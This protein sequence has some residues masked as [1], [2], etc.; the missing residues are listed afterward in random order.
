MSK[1]KIEWRQVFEEEKKFIQARRK[2]MTPE[3]LGYKES[4]PEDLVG[5]AISGGGIRS[6]TFG[7]GVLE[8]LK[9]KDL[10]NK[11]D[12]LS[13]VSGGGYI[14]GWL[15]ANCYRNDNWLEKEATN[16]GSQWKESISYLR[17]FS[18]Y[19][20][21][22]LGLLSADT[23][24]M[25]TVWLRNSLLIL[26]MIILTIASLLLVTKGLF[27][28]FDLATEKEDFIVLT[29]ITTA[30]LLIFVTSSITLYLRNLKHTLSNP[31][32]NSGGGQG[33]IHLSVISLMIGCF[34]ISILFWLKA[35]EQKLLQWGIVGVQ[36]WL[37]WGLIAWVFVSSSFFSYNSIVNGSIKI[38]KMIGAIL[39]ALIPTIVSWLLF[40]TIANVALNWKETGCVEDKFYAFAIMPAALLATFAFDCVLLIGMLGRASSDYFREWWSRFGAWLAIYGFIWIIFV[41]VIYLGPIIIVKHEELWHVITAISTAWLG[42]TLAGVFAGKSASTNGTN[43]KEV[44]AKIKDMVIKA[45]PIVFILGLLVALSVLLHLILASESKNIGELLI[46]DGGVKIVIAFVICIVCVGILSWRIDINEFSL[47]AFYRHRLTR[48]FLGASRKPVEREPHPFTG[49]DAKDD[50]KLAELI[51]QEEVPKGPLHIINCS[52]NLGGSSDLSVHTRHSSNFT[53]TPLSCGSSYQIKNPNGTDKGAIG[54]I[55]TKNYCGEKSQPTLGH[56]ISVSGAA[57]SPNSGYHTSAPVAFLLTLFNARLGWW[58]PNP[59]KSEWQLPSPRFSLKFILSELFGCANEESDFLAISDGGHF[60]NL[61]AYELIK[62][63]CKVII[64]SDGECDPKLQLEG[65][66]NLIRLCEVDGLAK[67]NIDTRAI[68]NLNESGWS[69]SRW[70]VGEI[71]YKKD[72]SDEWDADNKGFLI[73]LKASMNGNEYTPIMQY[74]ATHPDFPHETTGDQ[75][76][77]EDQFESYRVLAREITEELFSKIKIKDMVAIAKELNT[78]NT[79]VSFNQTQFIHHADRLVEIWRQLGTN[80]NLESFAHQLR[81]FKKQPDHSVFYI[82]CQMIQLIENIYLDL[83]LDDTWDHKNNEGWKELFTNWAKNQ[84]LVK[85]WEQTRHTYGKRFIS[86]WERNLKL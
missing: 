47:N 41:L 53:L 24:S 28:I 3:K 82:C 78:I 22:K 42:T 80:E 18:N 67:I 83:N 25:A 84:D 65:L 79:P 21:P 10:L 77:A 48:C 29:T 4:E 2:K 57:A 54:Y 74:K 40:T 35:G 20:S 69:S 51:N 60:E 70:A 13:T 9:Q 36:N 5:L 46:A 76:Y 43:Q 37:L 58:F 85:T 31:T 34:L 45:A 12:Y 1:S 50:L 52:L 15:S 30:V 63:K 71:T 68:S 62:R 19:L 86:F 16:E 81:N 7:L 17:R 59:T 64:I 66:A 61:A 75:F 56:A 33:M 44:S 55:E 72:G 38:K 73:Y 8:V 49:F 23:W 11:I 32:P 39:V 14:G 26:M 6:A 27:Q